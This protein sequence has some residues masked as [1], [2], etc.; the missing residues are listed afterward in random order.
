LLLG[1]HGWQYQNRFG[2]MNMDLEYAKS[3]QNLIHVLSDASKWRY[4]GVDGLSIEGWMKQGYVALKTTN[5]GR[6]TCYFGTTLTSAGAIT[7]P[8]DAMR[9][10]SGQIE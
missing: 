3:M 8:L 9:Q 1:G 7:A 4:D 10:F 2:T 6:Y 5:T